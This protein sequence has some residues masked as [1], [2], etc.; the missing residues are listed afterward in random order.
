MSLVLKNISRV[1]DGECYINN[2]TITFE[3]GSFNVLLGRTL[4]GKTS[5]MRL[6]AGLDKPSEGRL[7]MDGVDVTGVAV[8]KRNIAMVYQQFINY[9]SLT[10]FENIASP[11]RI[12]G[13]AESMIHKKVNEVAAML[14]IEPFLQRFPLELSG[15]QQQRTAMARAL[16]K[17]G[18]LILFDEPL[19]NLDYKLREEL[20]FE[21]R[22]LFK[23]KNTI[24]IYASTEPSEALALGGVTSLL[25]E[26][27]IIQSGPVNEVYNLPDS[28]EAAE[29][30]SEPPINI[31]NTKVANEQ[32]YI[33]NSDGFSLSKLPAPLPVGD[34]NI[35]IRP[36]HITLT[37]CHDDDIAIEAKVDV[38]EISGSETYLHVANEYLTMVIQL[39]GIH[40]FHTDTRLRVYL[41]VNKLYVFD[42][43]GKRVLAPQYLS[44]QNDRAHNS[45]RDTHH[46]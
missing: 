39:S 41:P 27:R 44:T 12:A 29:L 21:L 42:H 22:E 14:H 1:V 30:F 37:Q 31:L 46:G 26:G 34:Y 43:A 10:V 36:H 38:A 20:R 9:P 5:L 6:L 40:V 3:P 28:I 16:I 19:V 33:G 8:Q 2:A 25:H 11:L 45:K 15:G 4:A 7:F 23:V 18:G 35:G 13:V 17:E 24:A 32:V